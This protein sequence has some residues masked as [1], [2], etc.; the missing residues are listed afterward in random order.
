MEHPAVR[1]RKKLDKVYVLMARQTRAR[2][3]L[4]AGFKS[5]QFFDLLDTLCTDYINGWEK[6]NKIDLDKLQTAETKRGAK[7][8][9]KAKRTKA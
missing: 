3:K 7:S 6:F 8:S 2:L 9:A 4:V 5:M 1:S